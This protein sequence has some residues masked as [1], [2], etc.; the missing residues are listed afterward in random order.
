MEKDKYKDQEEVFS[1]MLRAGNRSY[2]FDVKKTKKEDFYITITESKKKF[3]DSGRYFFEKHKLFL[4]K[5][6]F[7]NFISGLKEAIDIAS[8]NNAQFNG[9]SYN[10]ERDEES[11]VEYDS[12][13]IVEKEFVNIEFEDLKD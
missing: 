2:F 13:D 9:N 4:Y 8:E 5:E 3:K 12:D 1:N 10:Y 6:D 11:D 7:E